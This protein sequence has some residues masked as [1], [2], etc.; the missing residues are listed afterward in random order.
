MWESL[1]G[2]KTRGKRELLFVSFLLFFGSVFFIIRN[3]ECIVR[4]LVFTLQ[5]SIMTYI[6]VL[7]KI[8]C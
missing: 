1:E 4:M 3:S 5:M 6:S 2:I 7:K 8:D